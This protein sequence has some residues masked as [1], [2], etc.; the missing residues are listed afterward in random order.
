MQRT[1]RTLHCH[2]NFS[3]G[4]NSISEMVKK[5]ESSG[6]SEIGISDHLLIHPTIEAFSFALD[7]KRISEYVMEAQRV[8]KESIISVKL[9]LEVDFFPKNPRQSEIDELISSYPFDFLIGSVHMLDT[10]T[11]DSTAKGWKALSQEQVNDKHKQYWKN[12]KL[13]AESKQFNFVGHIDLPKKLNFKPTCDLSTEIEAALI[14]IAKAGMAIELNTAGW[15][16]PCNE[17]YPSVAILKRCKELD[18]PI[19]VNDDAHSVDDLGRHFQ[20][21]WDL[22]EGL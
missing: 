21:A 3:D 5:A 4:A 8:A 7:L 9:G 10:F 17:Q 6:F 14:A 20:R 2:T 11:V 13:M 1:A 16:K 18:I 12:I 19:L 15:D 22:L